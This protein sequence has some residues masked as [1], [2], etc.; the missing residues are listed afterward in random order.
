V[1]YPNLWGYLRDL[2]QQPGIADTVKLEHIKQHYYGSHDSINPT[3]IVPAGPI[4]DFME[5]HG[6]EAL[7][8]EE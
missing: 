5:T 8:E 7:A 2:Y 4:I 1:D 6:R 3:R